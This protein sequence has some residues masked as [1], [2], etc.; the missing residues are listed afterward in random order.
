MSVRPTGRA[1]IVERTGGAVAFWD[2]VGYEVAILGGAT[3][4][5]LF[6]PEENRDQ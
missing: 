4:A 3:G 6:T 1:L 2:A 5:V